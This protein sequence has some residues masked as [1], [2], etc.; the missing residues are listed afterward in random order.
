M[1]SHFPVS[2]P[3]NSYPILLPF[4]SK[5]V[6]PYLPPPTP[7][8]P[9]LHPASLGHQPPQDQVSPLPLMPDKVILYYI[10]SWSYG[11]ANVYS[12]WWFSPLEP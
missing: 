2:L 4:A 9:F 7:T 1:L 6:L 3:Q 10:C 8:S 5:R 12:G 11:L